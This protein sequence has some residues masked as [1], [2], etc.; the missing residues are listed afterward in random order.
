MNISPNQLF[1]L[2]G[3]NAYTLKLLVPTGFQATGGDFSEYVT[4]ELT[5]P[6]KSQA[7]YHIRGHFTSATDKLSFRLLRSHGQAT[8]QSL[9][10]VKANLQVQV[11]PSSDASA[12][13]TND[14]CSVSNPN[15]SVDW[16][17]C[18]GVGGWAF[19]GATLTQPITV[20]VYVDGVKTY[21]NITA[22]GDR[23][24]L[25]TAFGSA[26]A[27]Y[28]GFMCS[29]PTNAAWKDGQS[30]S[31]SVR[32]CGASS[33][34]G[35]SPKT[36]TGCTGGC[37]PPTAPSITAS[38]CAGA[39]STATLTASGCSGT[40]TW[41][42]GA[43]GT[44]ISI[45]SAGTYTATC[46]QGGCS[47]SAGSIIVSSCTT[48]SANCYTIKAVRTGKFVQAMS[49]GSVQQIDANGQANQIWK[50]EDVGNSQVR[51][52][53]QNGSNQV[54]KVDNGTGNGEALS[55]G[56][57]SGDD[58]QK[59]S[60]QQDGTTG[61]YRIYRSNGYTWD[62]RGAGANPE[63][64]LY[65]TI[66]DPVYDYRQFQLI[67]STGCGNDTWLLGRY[68]YNG[69]VLTVQGAASSDVMLKF[70]RVDGVAFTTS[71]PDNVPISSGTYYSP[72]TFPNPVDAYSRQW[73]INLATGS[74]VPLRLTFR[75]NSDLAL[76]VFEFTPSNGAVQQPLVTSSCPAPSLAAS[77]NGELCNNVPVTL[78]A[79]GCSG[80]VNWST[81][82][83]GTSIN[84][85]SA[86]TYTATCTQSGCTSPAGSIL[87][88]TCTN[89]PGCNA[90]TT[91]LAGAFN[92]QPLPTATIP[93]DY[94]VAQANTDVKLVLNL[95]TGSGAS[96][97]LAGGILGIWDMN[98]P[99]GPQ[100]AVSNPIFRPGY[101]GDCGYPAG[102]FDLGSGNQIGLYR[103]PTPWV[104]NG[105]SMAIG[106]NPL[107]YGSRNA[108]SSQLRQYGRGL[109][110][111]ATADYTN[112]DPAQWDGAGM[113]TDDKF[114]K[115]V[116]VQGKEI[117]IWYQETLNR[118][119]LTGADNEQ[120]YPRN[121]EA[122]CLYA[123]GNLGTTVFYDG[124]APYTN[125]ATRSFNL[126]DNI[127]M[128]SGQTYL[129][130]NWIA[131][132]GPGGR[133]IGM[134]FETPATQIGQ[135][136]GKSNLADGT[137]FGRNYIA[138]Q[139]RVTIDKNIVWQHSVV[140]VIG[141]VEEIRQAAYTY[142]QSRYSATPE[143]RFNQAGRQLWS[144]INCSDPGY[145]ASRTNWPVTFKTG[146]AE[147]YSPA[148][149]WNGSNKK[150]YMRYRYTAVSRSQAELS[151]QWRRA[152]QSDTFPPSD[153]NDLSL[154]NQRFPDGSAVG[155]NYSKSATLYANGQW[156]TVEWD[157][158]NM[159]EWKGII[160]EIKFR[161]DNA[162]ANETL[163]IEWISGS[164]TGPCF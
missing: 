6:S 128:M 123:N 53:T 90:I 102:T 139:P 86:G 95:K 98:Y 21:T 138:W 68:S 75:R 3:S 111:G 115:W 4:G 43:T 96:N 20:D 38:G 157:M 51:F 153:P 156:N 89:P 93:A 142:T 155:S 160:N 37:T 127:G 10:E 141:T 55:M 149:A 73:Q 112:V 7:I 107:E 151:L 118:S 117:K 145:V 109:I 27:E 161:S 22:N 70:E 162:S 9:Y 63:L 16:A 54:I 120:S 81:G 82:A 137:A 129:T 11:L 40:V 23:P 146:G 60:L 78:T 106:D 66:T 15:G 164:Q 125:G 116:S 110:N 94:T 62:L 92:F 79:S 26:D 12:R 133:G 47:S 32:I 61:K 144:I 45:N 83:M 67:P 163:E 77:N 52:T 131:V 24:D 108:T 57:Y 34:L 147:I 44:S 148:A 100:N 84:V 65:G 135:F 31:I 64:Q 124:D 88:H 113:R 159:T 80:S 130:E 121:Q 119:S 33:D 101:C 1:F 132:I 30:H 35:G 46:T 71:N 85:N 91:P 152:R 28:H 105:T 136:N 158:S 99:N 143:Y 48:P 36:V 72:Y 87:V 49:D 103:L 58:R 56:S 122:P 154:W 14:V 69:S 59:W 76:L 42:T 41:S 18:D 19:D 74:V 150:V 25:V 104:Y 29:F 97:G 140:E 13:S 50:I 5:Y 126:A 114:E 2:P 8:S 17:T 39:S 134:I